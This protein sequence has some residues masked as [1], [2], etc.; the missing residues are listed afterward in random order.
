M[1]GY[2]PISE[3]ARAKE[4]GDK[5]AA[6]SR[7]AAGR[8]ELTAVSGLRF[9][10]TLCLVCGRAIEAL[11][12]DEGSEGRFFNTT[13]CSGFHTMAKDVVSF[14]YMLSGFTMCWGYLSRDFESADTRWRC[15]CVMLLCRM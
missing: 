15:A 7:A 14:Y 8:I 10:A 12:I 3:H 6:V 4:D 5:P 2:E 13:L 9:F 1:S 11:W